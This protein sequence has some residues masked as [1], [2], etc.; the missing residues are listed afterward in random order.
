MEAVIF[1][2]LQGSGKSTFYH[3][4]FDRTH[5]H[6]SL[7]AQKTRAQ[8]QK[9]LDELV[10][11]HKSFVVDNT[12]ATARERAR[13]IAPAKAAGY[14]VSGYYFDCPIADCLK[15]NQLRAGKGRIPPVGLYATRKRMQP[16]TLAEGFD[17]LFVVKVHQ[18]DFECA[19]VSAGQFSPRGIP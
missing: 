14:T 7:D 3:Q 2:G 19:P 16:P 10:R 15:R 6:V 8:E 4:R 5:A 9:R 12:N 11:D 13:Y 17:E 18:D 1:I